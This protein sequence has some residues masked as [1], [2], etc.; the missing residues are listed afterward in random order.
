MERTAPTRQNL[1]QLRRR[2]EV[3]RKGRELLRAKR[4]ALMKEFMGLVDECLKNREALGHLI[5]IAVKNLEVARAVDR[6]ALKSMI[7]KGKR[8]VELS[9]NVKNV[10]GVKIPEIVERPLVRSLDARDVSPVGESALVL[11][12][13]K[14]FEK[15]VSRIVRMATPE[16]RLAR[17]GEMIKSDS[18]KINALEEV[19]LPQIGKSVKAIERV[20][21]EREK[22]E[23]YRMKRYKSKRPA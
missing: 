7:V 22:E 10:W 15:V 2:R 11:D 20:L 19:M 6:E 21:E 23:I 17:V 5:N 13:A 1:M 9:I 14:A 8:D 18:R 16:A 4:E 3:V 12:T